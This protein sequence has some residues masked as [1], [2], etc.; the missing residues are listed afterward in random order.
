MAQY[1]DT[2]NYFLIWFSVA[3]DILILIHNIYTK[4]IHKDTDTDMQLNSENKLNM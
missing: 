4:Q 3:L 1:V 2:Y